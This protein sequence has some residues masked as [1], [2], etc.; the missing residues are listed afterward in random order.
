M[1]PIRRFWGGV[2]GRGYLFF[3]SSNMDDFHMHN[4][5]LQLTQSF[6]TH[7]TF[8]DPR[9][10]TELYMHYAIPYAIIGPD[11]FLDQINGQVNYKLIYSEIWISCVIFIIISIRNKK[12][13]L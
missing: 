9:W 7:H 8:I 3:L 1:Q 2:K 10:F 11:N 5:L 4:C 6:I 12:I 13:L